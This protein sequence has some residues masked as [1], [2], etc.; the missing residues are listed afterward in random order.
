MNRPVDETL[1]MAYFEYARYVPSILIISDR[2]STTLKLRRD[3]EGHGCRVQQ[4]KTQVE[5]LVELGHTFFDAIVLD[6]GRLGRNVWDMSDKLSTDREL[7]AIPVA[8]VLPPDSDKEAIADLQI[9]P[10]VYYVARKPDVG[11]RLLQ[12]IEEVHYLT[13]RYA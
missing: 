13:D 4:I 10:P 12:I 11:A 7:I 1:L 8:V 9:S 2:L 5:A 3:L 6:V